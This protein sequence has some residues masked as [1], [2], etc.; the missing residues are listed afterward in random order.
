MSTSALV[1][2]GLVEALWN[3]LAKITR[4]AK[5]T[6]FALPGLSHELGYESQHP[7]VL[8]TTTI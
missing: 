8:V 5:H 1:I 2:L 7:S 3:T 6:S 4:L